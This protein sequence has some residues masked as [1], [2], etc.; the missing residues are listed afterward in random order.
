MKKKR[1]K[2]LL[3]EHHEYVLRGRQSGESEG[4]IKEVYPENGE[5]IDDE[6]GDMKYHDGEYLD[7]GIDEEECECSI[8]NERKTGRVTIPNLE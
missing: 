6:A 4:S 7:S 1:K 8:D 2:S 5:M 3:Y